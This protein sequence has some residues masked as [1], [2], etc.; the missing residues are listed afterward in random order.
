M[1]LPATHM[2]AWLTMQGVDLNTRIDSSL[3]WELQ[4]AR[5]INADGQITGTG[6]INGQSHAFLMTP[7]PSA[8]TGAWAQVDRSSAT[9][10]TVVIGASGAVKTCPECAEDVR[11]EARLCRHCGHRFGPDLLDAR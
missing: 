9:F 2:D 11:V 5:G 1:I 4:N 3:A 7:L 6:T 10:G 8:G